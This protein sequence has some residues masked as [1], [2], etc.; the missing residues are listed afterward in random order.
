MHTAS[1]DEQQENAGIHVRL[2]VPADQEFVL[3]LAP[4][5]RIGVAPW[6]DP[7]RMLGAARQWIAGSVARHGSETVVFVAEDVCSKRLGFASVSRDQHFTGVPQ[8]YIGELAVCEAVEG[9]GGGQR[10]GPRVRAVGPRTGI[11]TDC[12]G[13]RVRQRTWTAFLRA[14]GF[15]RRERETGASPLTAKVPGVP[16]SAV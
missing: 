6:I 9:R 3:N 4:R 14:P 1:W 7:E 8:A 16:A 11:Y 2:Y 10:T 15:Q 13:H 5:L 12:A